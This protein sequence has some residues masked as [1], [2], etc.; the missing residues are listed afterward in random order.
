MNTLG[1]KFILADQYVFDP[2]SNTLFDR[3]SD[4][5][6]RLGSN[7]S[8]ILLMFVLHPSEVIKRDE[9][10]DFVWRQQGFEVDDSSLTQAISTL[11]KILNDSTKSPQFIKTVPKRGY[12]FISDVEKTTAAKGTLQAKEKQEDVTPLTSEQQTSDV[13]LSSGEQNTVS[14]LDT[15]EALAQVSS[16]EPVITS[17]NV[18]PQESSSSTVSPIK[19][20]SLSIKLCLL[21]TLL[22]PVVAFISDQP[23]ITEFNTLATY[24][25]VAIETPVNHPDLSQ[26]IPTIKLCLGKYK[27]RHPNQG[28]PVRIIATGGV[29]DKLNLNY[30]FDQQDEERNVTISVLGTQSDLSKLC[31]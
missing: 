20:W 5:S 7:E 29:E 1:T 28:M 31:R 16:V 10:H 14:E 4:E 26:W 23:K 11:R 12:Q 17:N 18:S 6:V 27:E 22:I 8:R 19:K 21:L 9:L 30:I 3:S 2:N 15:T 24:E 25:N 13:E